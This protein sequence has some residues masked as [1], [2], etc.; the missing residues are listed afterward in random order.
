MATS[1]LGRVS[2]STPTRSLLPHPTAMRL[3]TTQLTAGG[4]PGLPGV[5]AP[6]EQ[7]ELP[8]SGTCLSPMMR[9]SEIRVWS[10]ARPWAK[11]AAAS[12]IA[13]TQ[14]ARTD[15][16]AATTRRPRREPRQR[17][18]PRPSPMPCSD[19]GAESHTASRWEWSAD[20]PSGWMFSGAVAGGPAHPVGHGRP[21]LLC[22]L[23][24]TTTEM[25]CLDE[26]P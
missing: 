22:R 1:A 26:I 8:P 3:R 24:P 2:I 14:R 6:V 20:R 5:H 4:L 23:N 19:P 9:P 12:A 15:L 16:L 18:L 13:P 7:Q 17:S 21:A 11:V 10:R 25:P